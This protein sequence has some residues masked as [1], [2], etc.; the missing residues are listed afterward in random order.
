M[1]AGAASSAPQL[2]PAVDPPEAR[3]SPRT[4]VKYMPLP[5]VPRPFSFVPSS[6][7]RPSALANLSEMDSSLIAPPSDGSARLSHFPAKSPGENS[8]SAETDGYILELREFFAAQQAELAKRLNHQ[9]D[10]FVRQTAARLDALSDQVARRFST[11]LHAHSSQALNALMSD[12]AEQSRVLVDAEC[13]RAL[14]QFSAR[15]Q[16]LSAAH[17]ETYHK[18]MQ[19]L[20]SNLKSRLRS[21]AHALQE[22]GPASH[23]T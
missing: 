16:S 22:I 21:V 18:E 4:E 14:D 23:R 7:E 13:N 8:V 1:P 19:N 3:I 10:A 12:W 20:S 17:L 9:L 11:E 15:L 5:E 2:S 6:P